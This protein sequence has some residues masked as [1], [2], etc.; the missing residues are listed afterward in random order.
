VPLRRDRFALG[1]VY[2]IIGDLG[3]GTVDIQAHR[4]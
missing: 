3:G 4:R 1:T 2:D